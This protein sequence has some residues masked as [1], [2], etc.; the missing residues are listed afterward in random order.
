MVFLCLRSLI[1]FIGKGCSPM[2]IRTVKTLACVLCLQA[3]PFSFLQAETSRPVVPFEI[4]P[5]LSHYAYEEP[6]VMKTSGMMVGISGAVSC[7]TPQGIG[8]I[9]LFRIEAIA[10]RGRLDYISK[11]GTI[12]DIDDTIIEARALLGKEIHSRGKSIVTV[13]TGF[14]YR[15]LHDNGS[16][17]VTSAGNPYYD[18]ESNYS[19]I[20][21][22]L[23][24]SPIKSHGWGIGGLVEYDYFLSGMQESELTDADNSG[25]TYSDDL[26]NKQHHGYGLRA[27]LKATKKFHACSLVIE[28]FVR[29][30]KVGT[31]D[32]DT[33]EEY[34]NG[35]P[36]TQVYVEPN[37]HTTQYGLKVAL[38]F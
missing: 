37:N 13:Y 21:V 27:S 4:G 17:K 22:I 32:E 7:R 25:Y 26:K 16:G 38:L 19:F 2:S 18:R 14:G 6:G 20:P 34:E 31:S 12:K 8:F 35:D 11:D 15:Q 36:E 10:A 1:A 29:Y 28:P 24:L 30:W 3:L 5:E 9:D 33:I 23:E